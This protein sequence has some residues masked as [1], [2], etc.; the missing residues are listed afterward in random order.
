MRKVSEFLSKK[1]WVSILFATIILCI[2]LTFLSPVFLKLSN[3]RGVLVSASMTGIMAIGATFVISTAGIDISIGAIL[4]FTCALFAKL[5][6]IDCPVPLAFLVAIVCG[7]ALGALN[8][9]LIVKF[10][11]NA[12]ITNIAKYKY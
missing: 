6:S 9:L 12:M 5:L 1:R 11:M 3:I 2:V 4:F 10:K 8:G 7:T